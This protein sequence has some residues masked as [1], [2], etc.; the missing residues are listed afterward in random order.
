MNRTIAWG[1]FPLSLC[2]VIGGAIIALGDGIAPAT[3]TFVATLASIAIVA[4]FER[5]QPFEQDW[6]HS[7]G[8]LLTDALYIPTYLGVNGVIEPFVR[9]GSVVVGVAL[10]ESIGFG[11]WPVE[12]S[13]LAQLALACF[14]VEGFDYWPHRLLHE[15]PWLWRFHAIHHNPKRVYWMN[16]TRSHP[17]EIVFRG[18]ANVIPLA[19]LGADAELIALIAV[20]NSILGMY[21]HA[22]ID[23]ELGP[24]SWIFSVGEMHRWHHSIRLEE[25]NSNYGSNFLF[26]DIIFGTRFRDVTRRG[27]NEIGVA[28]DNLPAQWWRQ[29]GAPFR[30]A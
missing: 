15:I 27:P 28:N 24:L 25:A 6:N 19:L 26:W 2:G 10:S 4:T 13:I 8:D 16:A 18:I 12:W 11:L 22:N 20:V 9:A 23:F 7:K 30:R 1:L 17:V 5:I 3:V 29:M 21:Q 14:V